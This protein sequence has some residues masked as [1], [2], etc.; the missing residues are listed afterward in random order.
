MTTSHQPW[1]TNNWFVSPWN[2]VKEVTRD[3]MPPQKVKIHDNT[4]RDGEQQAGL[5]FTKEEKIQIAEKLAE[6]G[7]H[8]IEAGTPAASL[9]DEAAIRE[10]VRRKLGPEIICLSRCT[11]EDVKRA[12]DCG[13]D[14]INISIPGSKL[15]MELG[16]GWSL[17]RATDVAI[18]GTTLAKELGLYVIFA[19]V[20][21]TRADMEWY[22]R[23]IERI[24]K[25][26]HIDS[27]CLMDTVGS[28]APDAVGYIVRKLMERIKKPVE[29]HFHNDFGLCVANSIKAVLC[30]AEVVQTTVNG[31][32]ERSGNTPMEETV[33]A[34]LTL[35][36]IDTGIKCDKLRDVA[37][38]VERISGVPMV[39]N[40]GLVG[41]TTFNVGTGGVVEEYTRISKEASID[42][43]KVALFPIHH[44]FV[45]NKEPEIVLGKLS[46]RGNILIWAGRLGIE[47]TE[48]EVPDVV[49][50][51]KARAYAKK[52]G[53]S[54]AEFKMI[55]EQVKAKG[56]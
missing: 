1:K 32:G 27:L 44:A 24:A 52:A 45:G 26:G 38:M 34:L 15:L 29:A 25:E 18:K 35:Y 2:Y 19:A 28:L 8:R 49:R 9:H 3:F 17:E 40:R 43:A 50:E 11:E 13:V 39:P 51:V 33:L 20:D 5:M 37:K 48:E 16:Y 22:L 46:G 53:L 21:G 12:K 7:V 41:D 14:G 4:I 56:K 47:L 36:G 23:L 42:L 31:I 6:V 55:V 54:E 30:G 10:I